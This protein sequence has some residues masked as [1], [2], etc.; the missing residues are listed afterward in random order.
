MFSK[1][2]NPASKAQQIPLPNPQEC[3]FE[4]SALYIFKHA[5]VNYILQKRAASLRIMIPNRNEETWYIT[6]IPLARVMRG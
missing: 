4:S 5:D 2:L 1:M 6:R 3:L